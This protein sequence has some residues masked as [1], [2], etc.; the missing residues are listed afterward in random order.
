MALSQPEERRIVT[1]VFA[2]LVGFTT[3]AERMDPE[4]VKRLIDACFERLVDV[5]VEFGGKVDKILGDGMLVLFGAPVA[6]EDDPE[7]AVRAALRMQETLAHYVATSELAGS[8]DIRMRVGINTGEVLVGTLAGTDYTAM[9]D[10][11]NTAS[12][13]QAEAPAGGVLVGEVTH[14]LT[15]HTFRYEPAGTLQP[16]G[17]E[18]ALQRGS[19]SSPPPLP[20]TAAAGAATSASW[21]GAPSS[22]SP[23]R[24]W[25]WCATAAAGCCCTSTATTAWARAAT[26]TR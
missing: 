22:P 19:R 23:R 15:S 3:L 6:H 10:V 16:R 24:R 26:S 5:V 11:V 2:D 17:R 9:G 25:S 13:L 7:R 4:Q 20:A 21:A 8:A 14:G 12:R 1:I 18:Q